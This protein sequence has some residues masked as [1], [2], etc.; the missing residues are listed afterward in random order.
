MANELMREMEH[1]C[2]DLTVLYVEDEEIIREQMERIFNR[3]FKKVITGEDGLEGVEKFQESKPDLI[4]TDIRMPKLDGL[5]M[6]KKIREIQ[7]DIP[8]VITTAHSESSFLLEAIEEGVEQF[9]IKP[10]SSER[11]YKVII[12]IAKQLE[13]L[14]ESKAYK[15]SLEEAIVKEITKNLEFEKENRRVLTEILNAYPNPVLV[16]KEDKSIHYK[17]SAATKVFCFLD[18]S[19]KDVDLNSSVVEYN[20]EKKDLYS[21]DLEDSRKNIVALKTRHGKK[22]YRVSV[23]EVF[24]NNQREKLL[25]FI[26][27]TVEEYRKIQ[28]ENYNLRLES[29]IIRYKRVLNGKNQPF[30]QKKMEQ[31]I[32]ESSKEVENKKISAKEYR[33]DIDDYVLEKITDLQEIES[34]LEDKLYGFE[35]SNSSSSLKAMS[36]L[37]LQYSSAI[38]LL[39]EF[40]DLS[41]AV[42]DVSELLKGVDLESMQDEKLK[43]LLVITRAIISD[44]TQW[45]ETIFIYQ[46][47]QDIHYLDDS[48]LSSCLQFEV[49]VLNRDEEEIDNDLDLF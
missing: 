29:S 17:N 20:G 33:E 6:I 8:V 30:E 10:I 28:I 36:S 35:L 43:K 49:I 45:R 24:L 2:K 5:G 26:D 22:I 16:L 15:E 1:Y 44:L 3:F 14:R 12:K 48:L 38:S 42:R 23:D 39:F 40:E 19:L 4:I 37:F 31:T 46:N 41:I 27:I 13:V 18:D 47:T 32:Q 9:L 34:D 25:T 7:E 21:L 11:M